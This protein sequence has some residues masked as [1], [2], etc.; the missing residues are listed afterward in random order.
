[1]KNTLLYFAMFLLVLC[2]PFRGNEEEVRWLWAAMTWMPITLICISLMCIGLY[3]YKIK[4]SN[5]ENQQL[6]ISD[7]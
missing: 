1:M 5:K 3:L 4:R 7:K 6:T 2:L